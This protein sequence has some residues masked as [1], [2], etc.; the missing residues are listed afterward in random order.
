[1]GIS[2][3]SRAIRFWT[4]RPL[5]SVRE[6][7]RIRELG[8]NG[9]GRARNSRAESQVWGCQPWEEIDNSNDCREWMSSSTTKT[10]GVVCELLRGFEFGLSACIGLG[11]FAIEIAIVADEL[12]F[13][14]PK[15]R[16][17]LRIGNSTR[18]KE[19]SPRLITRVNGIRFLHD[20]SCGG[21]RTTRFS[22][23]DSGIV[24]DSGQRLQ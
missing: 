12:I 1:M 13:P 15:A 11:V 22:G 2:G 4:S 24:P 10:L 14:L 20:T 19:P 18:C 8:T 7:A 6:K 3:H 9:R 16:Q 17:P 23:Q 5:E 21:V